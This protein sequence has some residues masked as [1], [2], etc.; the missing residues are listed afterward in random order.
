MN[1]QEATKEELIQQLEELQCRVERLRNVERRQRKIKERAMAFSEL[2]RRLSEAH[3][4]RDAAKVILD[5]ADH[6]W[7]WDAGYVALYSYEDETILPVY[8][9]DILKDNRVEI[10]STYSKKEPGALLRKTVEEGPQLI[11]RDEEHPF[12]DSNPFGDEERKSLSLMFVPIKFRNK[13]RG[14][15]SIQSY[16][17][18]SYIED[19][20]PILQT[21]ADHCSGALERICVKEYSERRLKNTHE[22]YRKAI[23]SANGVPYYFKYNDQKYEF[24]GDGC[25]KLFGC[26]STEF[27]LR[28]L[29]GMLKDMTIAEANTEMTPLEYGRAFINGEM[30]K[31]S[32]DLKV[33]TSDG[34]IKWISDCCVP[35]KDPD[36]GKVTGSMGIFYDITHRK[37]TEESLKKSFSELQN[38]VTSVIGSMSKIVEIRDPYTSGHQQRV[39]LLSAALAREMG[40]SQEQIQRIYMSASIH[41][42]GKIS[43]PIEILS[44]PRPLNDA[45][46]IILRTHPRVG[47]DIL[48]TIEFEWPLAEIVYQHHERLDGS[49]YPRGL[50]EDEILKESRIIGVADVVEAMSYHRPYRPAYP[51]ERALSEIEKNKGLYYDPEVVDHCLNL[52]RNEGFTFLD[53]KSIFLSIL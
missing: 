18:Y 19:D 12:P 32:V 27:T 46:Q 48:K 23:V 1:S 3:D 30:E 34:K 45:E 52:F 44:C 4:R 53:T 43:V 41:D 50:E 11:L 35:I 8:A 37:K 29:Q 13:V 7:D 16:E 51:V 40:L 47:H 42:I 38:I 2:G 33:E 10:P 31:Y 15:L 22:I 36:T 49:G 28:K 26:P 6:F 20:L 25:E 5:I 9:V 17:S 14:V 21:L 24:I 39:A